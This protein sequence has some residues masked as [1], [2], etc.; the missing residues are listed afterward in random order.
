MKVNI[1]LAC[2]RTKKSIQKAFFVVTE[3]KKF[4]NHCKSSSQNCITFTQDLEKSI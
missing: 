2:K 1:D 4:E 3:Q